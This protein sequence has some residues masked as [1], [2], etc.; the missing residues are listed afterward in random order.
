ML[1]NPANRFPSETTLQA[2]RPRAEQLGYKED[3]L[4]NYTAYFTDWN[5][6][7]QRVEGHEKFQ[8]ELEQSTSHPYSLQAVP[9]GNRK[10]K[11]RERERK[12]QQRLKEAFDVLRTVIPD[13]FSGIEP[14]DRLTRIQTLRLAKKYIASLRQLLG[15]S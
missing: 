7:T 2:A 6:P 12:R 9:P 5:M 10:E 1:L 13:N 4:Q 11:N 15:N 3:Q 8:L 14:G